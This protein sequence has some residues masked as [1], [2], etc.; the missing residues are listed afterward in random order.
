MKV[1]VVGT[2]HAGYEAVQTILKEMLARR[3]ICMNVVQQHR[4]YLV[5]FKVI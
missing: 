2:S 1:I 5:G 3:F 4:F